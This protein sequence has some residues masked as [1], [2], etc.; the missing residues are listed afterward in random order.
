MYPD[1]EGFV[2]VA[3]GVP[4]FGVPALAWVA[5]ARSIAV[6]RV[7]MSLGVKAL[8]P[9]PVPGAFVSVPGDWGT[10]EEEGKT[11][12][13]ILSK[14]A[15]LNDSSGVDLKCSELIERKTLIFYSLFFLE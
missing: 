11:V 4:A 14:R 10:V 8:S 6:P 5:S 12:V 1:D 7:V 15:G 13:L 2:V 3:F 9:V